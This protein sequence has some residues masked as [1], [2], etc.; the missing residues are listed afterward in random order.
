MN[1]RYPDFYGKPYKANE[2][3]KRTQLCLKTFCFPS[4]QCSHFKTGE[5]ESLK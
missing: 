4:S 5:L 3:F 2:F 1:V